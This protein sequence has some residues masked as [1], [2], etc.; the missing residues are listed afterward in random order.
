MSQETINKSL[1][2]NLI[3]P[4]TN[5]NFWSQF[6]HAFSYE[7]ENQRKKYESIKDN[8]NIYSNEKDGVIRISNT[9]G[10]DPNLVINNTLNMAIKESES[11]PYRIKRK[12]TYDGYYMILQQNGLYGE[13]FNYY[14]DNYKLIKAIDYV[15]TVDNLKNS[16]H[17]SPFYGVSPLKNYSSVMNNSVICLDYLKDG[18]PEYDDNH[19]RRYSL[20]QTSYNPCWRLDK[21][22]TRIP[23]KH[24]GI[25]YYPRHYYCEYSVSLGV[26][27]EDIST[28]SSYLKLKD[29]YISKSMNV[30]INNKILDLIITESDGKEYYSDTEGILNPS[31]YYDIENGYLSLIF[32]IIPEG[33]DI[34]I[35]YNINLLISSDHLY[36]LELGAE[37][38]KRCPIVPHAGVFLTADIFQSKGTD[39]AY[40][41]EGGYT[42]PDIKLKALTASSYNREISISEKMILDNAKDE[43]GL[44]SGKSNFILD[45]TIK[46]T[47]DAKTTVLQDI[48]K[49]FKYIAYGNGALPLVNSTYSDIFN[50]N[51]LIFSYNFNTDDD[52]NYIYD[53]SKNQ[54]TSEVVGDTVKVNGIIDKSL[55]FNGNT[56]TYSLTNLTVLSNEDYTL[57][58]WFNSNSEPSTPLEVLFDNFIKISYDYENEK[59]HVDSEIIDC[60]KNEN[61]FLCLYFDSANSKIN[62]YIDNELQQITSFTVPSSSEIIYIGCDKNTNNKFYG[63]I[64]NIWMVNKKLSSNEMDYVYNNKVTNVSHMGNRIGFYEL[65]DEEL[66]ESDDYTIVQSYI[67]TMNVIHEVSILNDTGEQYYSSQTNLF[68]IYNPYF[69]IKFKNLNGETVTLLSNEKG[70][71]YREDTNEIITGNVDFETGIWYLTKDTIKSKSQQKLIS[72]TSTL[73]SSGYRVQNLINPT[74]PPQKWYESYNFDTA[75]P[76]NPI[77][78]DAINIKESTGY[79]KT[80]IYT[81]SNDSTPRTKIYCDNDDDVYYIRYGSTDVYT[82]QIKEFKVNGDQY[83]TKLFSQDNGNNLYLSLSDL[84]A[85]SEEENLNNLKCFVDLGEFSSTKLYTTSKFENVNDNT[86]FKAYYDV[87]CSPDKRIRKWKDGSDDSIIGYTI[88]STEG[89]TVIYYSDLSFTSIKSISN[90]TEITFIPMQTVLKSEEVEFEDLDEE[91]IVEKFDNIYEIMY[92]ENFSKVINVDVVEMVKN[93]ITFDYWITI[94]DE[95]KKFTAFVNANGQVSGDYIEYGEFDYITDT[96]SVSFQRKIESDIVVSYSYYSSLDID[97]TKSLIINYKIDKNIK[98]NEIGLEDENHELLAYMTFPDIEPNNIY[99]NVSAM[100]AINLSN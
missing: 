27:V 66:Y 96:L 98:I 46:W 39:Y 2:K 53:S 24:L 13:I 40:N 11:I 88:G 63:L 71:F 89:G 87:K 16:D 69:T 23:T 32:D 38:N 60:S 54:I 97:I 67:K 12:T 52:S 21:Q 50:M 93:T 70:N 35:S 84:I 99:N 83:E 95:L 78:S 62:I 74:E 45:S 19:I 77:V 64:D 8:Y 90:P 94:D 43:Q 10:Y 25:E 56:Y 42:V 61:H 36:C 49:K 6:L 29:Y 44:P 30:I 33:Y 100:F 17:Y 14:Y 5:D 80:T 1:Q 26:G 34:V 76:L 48:N 7:L 59:L 73:L 85:G 20:D 15:S 55:N 91:Q 4:L 28:Y 22:Y 68:P 47:L 31:S 92:I 58:M 18:N 9:F 82:P 72:P 3:S 79:N 57:S 51:N 65:S 41:N 81:S 86:N 75:E 37:Y